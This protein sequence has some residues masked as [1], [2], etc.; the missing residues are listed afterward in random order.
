VPDEPADHLRGRPQEGRRRAGR[1]SAG[2]G[3]RRVR[4]G[5]DRVGGDRLRRG[6]AGAARRADAVVRAVRRLP[7]AGRRH[8]AGCHRRG[9]SAG[10]LTARATA[11]WASAYATLVAS[12]GVTAI[13]TVSGATST[14]SAPVA[15]GNVGSPAPALAGSN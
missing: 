3:G 2:R 12:C 9:G 7:P 6:V 5:D 11:P 13:V 1:R 15:T 14:T 8:R 10:E 4:M